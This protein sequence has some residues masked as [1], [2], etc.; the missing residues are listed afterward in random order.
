MEGRTRVLLAE[1][2]E[3]RTRVQLAERRTRVLLAELAEGKP[4][5]LTWVAAAVH[6]NAMP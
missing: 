5:M 1:L 6:W 3:R 2:A 4:Q